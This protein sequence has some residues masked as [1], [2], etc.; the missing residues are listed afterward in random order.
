MNDDQWTRG[1]EKAYVDH[2][3]VWVVGACMVS[4]SLLV[5]SIYL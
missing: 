5:G 2:V 1:E 3:Y 4:V